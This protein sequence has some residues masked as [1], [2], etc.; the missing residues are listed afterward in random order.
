MR[1]IKH[2]FTLAVLYSSEAST[3]RE[4][5]ES[6][7]KEGADLRRAYLGGA[8]LRGAYLRD[9]DLGGADLGRADLGDADLGGADL[10]GANLRGANLGGAYLRDADLGGADLGGADLGDADLGGANLGGAD[11]RDADLRDADLGDAD[12]RR[13]YLPTKQKIDNLDGKILAAID[14]GG[15]LR[16]DE[17]HTCE[18]THCRAGWAITLAGGAGRVLEEIYGPSV[19]GALIYAAS[20]PDLP[21]P[22]F[23]VTNGAAMADMRSRAALAKGAA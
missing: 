20:Y 2:R 22:D 11:L 8:N 5:V 13:A 7:V 21:V 1:E 18:S 9:A 16:M 10:G 17:W 6:A 12:L 23:T 4:A 14:A 15:A 19:A 3:I